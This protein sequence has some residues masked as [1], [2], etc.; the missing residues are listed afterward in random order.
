MDAG[1]K[2]KFPDVMDIF[3]Y[4]NKESLMI[5]F[6]IGFFLVIFRDF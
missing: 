2:C 1:F 4:K 5:M 6:A 3:L